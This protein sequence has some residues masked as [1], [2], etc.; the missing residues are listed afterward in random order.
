MRRFRVGIA[1]HVVIDR[2]IGRRLSY[3]SVGGVPTYAG[4]TVASLGHTALAISVIGDDGLAALERLRGL[5]VSVERVRV[6]RGAK[7]TRYEIVQLPEGGRRLRL[8]ARAPDV[9]AED[10]T[11]ELDAMHYGPVA[12]ELRPEDI[13]VTSRLYR[14]TALD[15]QGLMRAFDED[16]NVRLEVGSLDLE[17]FGSVSVLRL[18][19]EETAA[20]GYAEPSQAA[21][22]LAL[23]TGRIVAVTAGSR[24]SFV[25]DGLRLVRG[26]TEVEAVDTVGA[27]DVFGGALLVGLMETGDLVYATALGLAAVD[28]RVRHAGPRALDGDAIRRAASELSRKISVS[29]VRP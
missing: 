3:E 15:P 25:S 1:G 14:W 28:Q 22:R 4:L 5:G 10:L 2:V 20:L 16:G 6:V 17:T 13:A 12:G 8:L 23:S 11:L 26:R 21:V 7:T 24:G 18:A 27:G 9:R 29:E 19:L